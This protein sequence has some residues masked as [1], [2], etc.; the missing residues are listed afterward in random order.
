MGVQS[1]VQIITYEAE[2]G[3]EGKLT[4]KHYALLDEDISKL[5]GKE[6]VNSS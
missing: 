3:S 2:E 5:D 1:K 4:E 6:A